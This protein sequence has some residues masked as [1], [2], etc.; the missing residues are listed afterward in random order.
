MMGHATGGAL[1]SSTNVS[2]ALLCEASFRRT[3]SGHNELC[4]HH[5]LH[6]V[7]VIRLL[8]RIDSAKTFDELVPYF[9]DGELPDLLEELLELGFIETCNDRRH[10]R[11][12]ARSQRVGIRRSLSP[13]QFEAIRRAT[14]N[15]ATE[16]LGQ[17]AWQHLHKLNACF[18]TADLRAVLD[19]IKQHIAR[20]RGESAVQLFMESV[21]SAAKR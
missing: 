21:R 8:A 11:V 20:T 7:E 6:R 2:N 19:D 16:L 9:R 14:M 15:G 5:A 4:Y 17:F 12:G 1:R 13:M 3:I 18:D 10:M